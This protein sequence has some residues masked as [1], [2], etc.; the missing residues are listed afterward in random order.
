MDPRV[1]DVLRRAHFE[2]HPGRFV[3]VGMPASATNTVVPLG[4]WSAALQ[5]GD[6]VT[7]YVPEPDWLRAA[8]RFPE[9]KVSRGWRMITMHA[10]I[11]WDL[12]GVLAELTGALARDGIPCAAICAYSTDHLLVPEARLDAAMKALRSLR[13]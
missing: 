13:E 2:A 7:F 4:P 5:T 8:P 6:E 9:A 12:H 10:A 11:P 1:R 3:I